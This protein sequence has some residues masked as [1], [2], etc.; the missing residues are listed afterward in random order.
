MRTEIT[1]EDSRESPREGR[2]DRKVVQRSEVYK[3]SEV[4]DETGLTKRDVYKRTDE[5]DETGR[6][7][8]EI[9]GSS[10]TDGG[11]AALPAAEAPAQPPPAEAPAAPPSAETPAP[12]PPVDAPQP[13]QPQEP[14][15]NGQP[16]PADEI[17]PTQSK[18]PAEPSAVTGAPPSSEAFK[19]LAAALD[20]AFGT[21]PADTSLSNG[22][23]KAEPLPN[24]QPAEEVVPTP[25]KA[26]TE[27]S[28][29]ADEAKAE[30]FKAL[31]A[32]LDEAITPTPQ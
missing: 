28:A 11:P 26:S 30:A 18:Q 9:S 10:T 16:A 25:A 14:L 29:G 27:P 5:T 32:V 19:A 13:Q 24:G 17:V 31:A 7:R 22:P 4:T 20:D 23:S 12:P 15:P 3:K 21:P 8:T 1:N 6:T 2:R